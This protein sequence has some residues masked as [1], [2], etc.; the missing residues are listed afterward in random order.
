M[1]TWFLLWLVLVSL[2]VLYV[3]VFLMSWHSGGE[4]VRII[5]PRWDAGNWSRLIFSRHTISSYHQISVSRGKLVDRFKY[6][7]DTR[8]CNPNFKF[9]CSVISSRHHFF[10]NCSYCIDDILNL[11]DI[12]ARKRIAYD[13]KNLFT[14][15][16]LQIRV[17]LF[18]KKIIDLL[19]FCLFYFVCYFLYNC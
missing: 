6:L 9:G 19:A 13:L 10:F 16:C 2:G 15:S 12:C 5:H 11:Q 3:I 17:E 1:F 8:S 7:K 18:L 14:Q 4:I